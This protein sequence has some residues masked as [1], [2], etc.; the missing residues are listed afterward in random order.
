MSAPVVHTLKHPVELRRADGTVAE[1]IIE[2]TLKRLK[3][4]DTRRVMNAKDKGT[5]DFVQALVC[6]AAQIPPSTFDQLDGEDIADLMEVAGGFLG[7]A[8]TT[9]KT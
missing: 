5:G 3:G 6:A 2:L 9:S 8:P 7:S 4:G 1:T